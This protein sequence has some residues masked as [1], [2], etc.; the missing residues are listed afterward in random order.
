M[1]WLVEE[2][3]RT[4][5]LEMGAFVQD[6]VVPEAKANAPVISGKLQHSITPVQTG[7]FKWVIS[8]HANGDN[9]FAYPAH[10][11]AGQGVHA[12]RSPFLHFKIHGAD[13]YTKGTRPSQKSHF[14][15]NT[16]SSFK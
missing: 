7:R 6:V 11:E 14:M 16:V 10:I 4:A 9:G 13:I 3:E 12:T 2:I 8:T 15:K 1:V 5:E